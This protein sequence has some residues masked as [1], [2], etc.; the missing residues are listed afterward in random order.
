[1][2][3]DPTA[4]LA[5]MSRRMALSEIKRQPYRSS[6]C[7]VGQKRGGNPGPGVRTSRTSSSREDGPLNSWVG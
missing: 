7:K 3:P 5:V 6:S 4:I 1:M 2:E